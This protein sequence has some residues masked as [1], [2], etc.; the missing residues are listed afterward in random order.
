MRKK[1]KLL[2]T[3]IVGI[4]LMAGVY[5]GQAVIVSN[6]DGS[7]QPGSVDDPLVTKSYLD[8]Q[9]QKLTG[10]QWTG[11]G[12]T[13]GQGG[14]G[15]TGAGQGVSEARVQEI[16][17]AELAKLKQELQGQTSGNGSAAVQ[18]GTQ[19]G[20][21]TNLEVVKLGA[22]Q[23]LY[24]GAGTELIV[25]TGKT[26]AVSNDDGIPD[27][28]EGIDVPAGTA[29]KNNHLLVFPREGR[30]IKPD[31]NNKD[32]IYVMIRGGYILLNQ[33]KAQ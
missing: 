25:R 12:Q 8:E 4:G 29:I 19:A 16:V 30:G 13:G 22:G 31:P 6:A 23:I 26:I 32:E 2:I 24:A 11:G 20:S 10:G 28:T 21:S 33:E 27:V 14:T 15:Q 17:A 9:L 3:G 18:P 1:R 5:I 7:V